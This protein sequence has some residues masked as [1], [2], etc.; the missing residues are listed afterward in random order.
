MVNGCEF[1]WDGCCSD[2]EIDLSLYDSIGSPQAKVHVTS[3]TTACPGLSNQIHTI[4]NGDYLD[5]YVTPC[6]RFSIVVSL[7]ECMGCI[8][9]A[10]ILIKAS[11]WH[12]GC[13]QD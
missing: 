13:S 7:L 9:I 1:S 12:S 11:I 3:C 10:I 5:F 4:F 2:V 6:V 8:L